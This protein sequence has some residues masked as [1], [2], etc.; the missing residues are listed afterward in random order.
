MGSNFVAK[1]ATEILFCKKKK[2]C[3][4]VRNDAIKACTFSHR[5]RE[6]NKALKDLLI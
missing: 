4:L 1:R 5:A 6:G 2:K 3:L